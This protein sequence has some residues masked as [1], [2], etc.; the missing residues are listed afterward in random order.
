MELGVENMRDLKLVLPSDL[1][2]IGMDEDTI[3][4]VRQAVLFASLIL[5][6]IDLRDDVFSLMGNFYCRFLLS[7]KH[8]LVARPTHS[9]EHRR[10]RLVYTTMFGQ[11]TRIASIPLRVPS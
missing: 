8:L 4:R 5:C 2:E 9:G 10:R 7:P 11:R 3:T 1:Y 6:A